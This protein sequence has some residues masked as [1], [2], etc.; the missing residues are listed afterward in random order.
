M[1][2]T[3][4]TLASSTNPNNG[5]G[6]T[7]KATTTTTTTPTTTT[8]SAKVPPTT[9][10]EPAAVETVKMSTAITGIDFNKLTDEMKDVLSVNLILAFA[11][12]L[13]LPVIQVFCLLSAGSVQVDITAKESGNQT[14]AKVEAP[15]TS[16][17]ISAVKAVPNIAAAMQPGKT[18]GAK[19]VQAVVFKKN[20]TKGTVTAPTIATTTT[21]KATTPAATA[22][23]TAG[24]YVAVSR[25][26][27]VFTTTITGLDFA[28]MTGPMKTSLSA[29]LQDAFAKTTG[30]SNTSKVTIFLAKGSV[31]VTAVADGATS[32]TA[33]TPE[34]LLAK[35]NTVSLAA[36][37]ETGK[38]LAFSAPA[39]KQYICVEGQPDN[40]RSQMSEEMWQFN[41]EVECLMKAEQR[42][43][44]G[45]YWSPRAQKCKTVI[46][47]VAAI[48]KRHDADQWYEG[49]GLTCLLGP[50]TPK[51][52]AK[53]GVTWG[54]ESDGA[55]RMA[56]SATVLALLAAFLGSQQLSA[57]VG[58]LML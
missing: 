30:V 52:R 15:A 50:W 51:V 23:G 21:P 27:V 37:K 9:L 16:S 39:A 4:A 33:P 14:F 38:S 3:T 19:K 18:I 48:R 54:T 36:A 6:T 45:Y 40:W 1:T 7:Q 58:D 22:K 53:N 24:P 5:G 13:G 41:S 10:S 12:S 20:Q 42:K 55:W 49:N 8:P 34:V 28:K 56:S 31:A 17:L 29:V 57:M 47:D 43:S 44:S 11:T 32:A 35:A 2:T 26:K 25:M 46:G